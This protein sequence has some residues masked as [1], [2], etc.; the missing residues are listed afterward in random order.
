MIVSALSALGLQGKKHLLPS[1][2]LIDSAASNHIT[3]TPA[4]LHNVRKYDGEQH[5]QI[6]DG[7][8]LPITA[9]GNLGSSFTNVF[10]SPDL[11]ANLI[12]VGQLV[13]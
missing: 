10:V 8:T 12:S 13:E 7:S 3:G 5:I 9:V 4:A 1:P 6:A 11:S 2:W